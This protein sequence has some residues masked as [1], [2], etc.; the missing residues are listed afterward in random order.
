MLRTQNEVWWFSGPADKQGEPVTV[1]HAWLVAPQHMVAGSMYSQADRVCVQTSVMN[2]PVWTAADES[3]EARG[4][5]RPHRCKEC[6]RILRK[7]LR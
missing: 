7:G 1:R 5:P 3:T 4:A 2:A 6:L